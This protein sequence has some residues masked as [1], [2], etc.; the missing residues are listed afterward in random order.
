[1]MTQ[2]ELL[3]TVFIVGLF[4]P[5]TLIGVYWL[6]LDQAKRYTDKKVREI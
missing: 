1:M 4:V 5:I 6:A 3:T 2:Y